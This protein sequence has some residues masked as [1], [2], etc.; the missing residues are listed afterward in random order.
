ME[1]TL[2]AEVRDG[3]GKGVAR[4]LRAQGRVPGVLYGS[5]VEPTSIHMSGQ[6]LLHLFHQG[7]SLVDLEVDGKT[8]LVIPR[9][10]QRDH[11]RGRYIHVDFFA[12]SRT[13]KVTLTVEV[14]ETGEAPGV[15]TGGVVEH[16]LRE[17][18]I[19]CMP[20]DVP[21]GIEADLSSLELGDMLRVGDLAVP[22]GVTILTDPDTPVI[23]IVTPA[24]L[25]TEVDLSVPGEEGVEVPVE[26]APA[27][28][29]APA[30]EEAA[31]A[32]EGGEG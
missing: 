2:K 5:G 30:E 24:I 11:L 14:R 3:A 32:E 19:E 29:A 18:D 28:E 22:Q 1:A 15:K 17:I 26:E 9:D 16:H 27:E 7:A 13:E 25:R 4:K 12:V 21:E 8:H 20:G 6:D 31:P 10:V 23:S